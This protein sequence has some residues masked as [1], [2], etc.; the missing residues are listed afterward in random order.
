[1]DYSQSM[2][3]IESVKQFIRLFKETSYL[4]FDFRDLNNF[5]VI[6]VDNI[7][8]IEPLQL[9]KYQKN[10]PFAIMHTN[11]N[12]EDLLIYEDALVCFDYNLTFE[13]ISYFGIKP[14]LSDPETRKKLSG[15]FASLNNQIKK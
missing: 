3:N 12:G 10:F 4:F 15:Q 9:P 11:D 2:S 6:F 1:M 8:E 14:N 13:Y 5:K 7:D